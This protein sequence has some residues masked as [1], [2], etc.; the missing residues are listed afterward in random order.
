M[1]KT[2]YRLTL[3]V[4][5]E[6]DIL[7]REGQVINDPAHAQEVLMRVVKHDVD[8][9]LRATAAGPVDWDLVS[10][11]PRDSSVASLSNPSPIDSGKKSATGSYPCSKC[12]GQHFTGEC[13]NG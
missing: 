1:K 11:A 13:P 9:A 2:W 5:Y 4:A 6:G 10:I 8:T 3:D 12:H 7:D